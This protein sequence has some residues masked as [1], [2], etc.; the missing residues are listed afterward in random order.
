METH[1]SNINKFHNNTRSYRTYEEWKPGGGVSEETLNQCSYRTY[2]EWKH[3]CSVTKY[4][5][6]GESSYRTYEEW[7]HDDSSVSVN[8][9]FAS[10]YRTYEEWKLLACNSSASCSSSL[11]LPYL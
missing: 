2:E 10:S 9:S 3:I 5:W 1:I 8:F 6:D 7:K 11:F 4:I